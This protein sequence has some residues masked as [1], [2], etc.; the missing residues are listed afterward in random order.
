[1][2]L[3]AHLPDSDALRNR[4]VERRLR[5]LENASRDAID[6]VGGVA[7]IALATLAFGG[8]EVSVSSFESTSSASATDLAT[9]GPVASVV[10]GTSGKL[11]VFGSAAQS[12]VSDPAG[13]GGV[14]W[15]TLTGTATASAVLAQ[16]LAP[17]NT[18][19]HRGRTR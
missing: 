9:V 2:T 13:S 11:L 1:M 8:Q 15:A 5:I 10:V 14:I 6:P 17:V 3:D 18:A 16:C 12:C 19:I 4:D 7:T